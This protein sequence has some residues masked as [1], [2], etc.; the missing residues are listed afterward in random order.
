[1]QIY[2]K[3]SREVNLLLLLVLFGWLSTFRS[4]IHFLQIFIETISK[5]NFPF[6]WIALCSQTY[7][8]T[9][10]LWAVISTNE[11]ISSLESFLFLQLSL[12]LPF[13]FFPFFIGN[14]CHDFH[15][16][17][18]FLLSLFLLSVFLIFNLF[19]KH[20]FS[21]LNETLLQ[22]ILKFLIGFFLLNLL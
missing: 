2:F 9:H 13:F 10:S 14:F 12:L 20:F 21:L 1:M 7:M 17:F 18:G 3:I 6:L 15:I 11:S 16:S 5:H 4:L 22:P 19:L 8:T